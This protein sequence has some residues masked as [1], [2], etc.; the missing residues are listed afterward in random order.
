MHKVVSISRFHLTPNQ[1]PDGLDAGFLDYSD[2]EGEEV[3]DEAVQQL[4]MLA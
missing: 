4:P 2:Y 1:G 3:D